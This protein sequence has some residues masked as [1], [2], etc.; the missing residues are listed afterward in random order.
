MK[1]VRVKFDYRDDELNIDEKDFILLDLVL[2]DDNTVKEVPSFGFIKEGG[3]RYP[4][5][6]EKNLL[7]W[8]E[9]N[10]GDNRE[11]LKGPSSLSL[12]NKEILSGA[13]VHRKDNC[14]NE[15]EGG[16]YEYIVKDIR[17]MAK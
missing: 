5:I 14:N 15:S 3:T 4:V 13:I 1:T 7:H 10:Y 16:D 2:K 6:F 8:D 17:E 12:L 11:D 9:S